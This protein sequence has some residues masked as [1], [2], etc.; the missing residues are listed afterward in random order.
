MKY[1]ITL[2][3][4]LIFSLFLF[5]PSAYAQVNSVNL[6]NPIGGSA[7]NSTD[8]KEVAAAAQGTINIDI[9]V[10]RV[11]STALGIIGSLTLLTFVYGGFLWLTSGGSPDNIKKG[12]TVMVWAAIGVF[13]IFSSYAILA[14]VFEGIG[15]TGFSK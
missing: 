5:T 6:I 3:S 12:K 9:L 2:F 14:A 7:S 11:I 15:V 10:G 13:I 8:K 4:I 1:F